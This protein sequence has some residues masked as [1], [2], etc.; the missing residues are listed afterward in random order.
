MILIDGHNLLFAL[1]APLGENIVP[2]LKELQARIG[3]IAAAERRMITMVFDGQGPL[4]KW[5][6]NQKASEWLT[7]VYSGAEMSAD[8]WI[9]DWITRNK[10]VQV[11]LLTNDRALIRRAS[12]PGLN[13]ARPESWV[14]QRENRPEPV[15]KQEFGSVEE[16]LD[17]FKEDNT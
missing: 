13:H 7:F 10:G 8:D 1:Y 15:A 16:W 11:L 2:L 12:R 9:V 17:Y 6:G 5:G 3:V 14:H 4:G